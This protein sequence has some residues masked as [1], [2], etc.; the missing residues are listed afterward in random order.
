MK[1]CHTRK[2]IRQGHQLGRK[3]CKGPK[4]LTSDI[5]CGTPEILV[6]F[7]IT[8]CSWNIQEKTNIQ[9][10]LLDCGRV[11]IPMCGIH[12]YLPIW[13]PVP[14]GYQM[15]F[16]FSSNKIWA[17]CS[18]IYQISKVLTTIKIQENARFPFRYCLQHVHLWDSEQRSTMFE[19]KTGYTV[20]CKD[21]VC[22]SL[23]LR[24]RG[25]AEGLTL[26][27]CLTVEFEIPLVIGCWIC[28]YKRVDTMLWKCNIV[29]EHDI[30]ICTQCF[31]PK[32]LYILN[33]NTSNTIFN[34]NIKGYFLW[35]SDHSKGIIH[36]SVKHFLWL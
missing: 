26:V 10:H 31:T 21:M 18:E 30:F 2:L 4:C 3:P 34:G 9:T 19:N 23:P 13:R 20:K 32:S 7:T 5:L 35:V 25:C 16:I 11:P 15:K 24:F 33:I 8:E 29:L 28:M 1:L 12:F 6:T 22:L 27:T 17:C 36:K 14:R